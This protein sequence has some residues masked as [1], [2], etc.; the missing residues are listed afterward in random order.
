M[1]QRPLPDTLE[2]AQSE[3]ARARR[4]TRNCA[5]NTT[6]RG[7]EVVPIK[8]ATRQLSVPHPPGS[9]SP[10]AL[11]AELGFTQ[12]RSHKP[13]RGRTT[14]KDCDRRASSRAHHR[15]RTARRFEKGFPTFAASGWLRRLAASYSNIR[16]HSRSRVT[17]EACSTKAL[18]EDRKSVVKRP[19]THVAG[20]NLGILMRNLIGRCSPPKAR[21]G[22]NAMSDRCSMSDAWYSRRSGPDYHPTSTI[23]ELTRSSRRCNPH[24]AVST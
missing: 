16:V 18:R 2:K 12:A 23:G 11:S 3:S 10:Q 17:R 22:L 9:W 8:A 21:R 24:R 13:S 7:S 4:T 15:R 6:R 14:P 1:T 19:F 20:F 5:T